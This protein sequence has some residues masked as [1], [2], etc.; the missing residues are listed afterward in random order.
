M[1]R[2]PSRLT[3]CPS[4]KSGITHGSGAARKYS[5][6]GLLFR[7]KAAKIPP[8][9]LSDPT[10]TIAVPVNSVNDIG[11]CL[12]I[13]LIL[14]VRGVAQIFPTVVQAVAIFVVDLAFGPFS[15]HPEPRETACFVQAAPEPDKKSSV[16]KAIRR[17]AAD[18]WST[19]FARFGPL[20]M[21]SGRI[22]M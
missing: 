21:S 8:A 16:S 10:I 15:R 5:S 7:G 6:S 4:I 2:L 19:V 3:I 13:E 14:R 18:P 12:P 17:N 20:E 11:F 22:V 1:T 9:Q